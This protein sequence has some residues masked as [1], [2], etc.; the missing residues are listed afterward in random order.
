MKLFRVTVFE[1]HTYELE[2][3]NA[4]AANDRVLSGDVE[5]ID[6]EL[7]GTDVEEIS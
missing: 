5:K 4:K 3:E 1:K 6:A 2:A 7:E